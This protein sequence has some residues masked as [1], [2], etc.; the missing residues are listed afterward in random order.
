MKKY[1]IRI[2]NIFTGQRHS[3]VVTGEI[4]RIM[5]GLAVSGWIVQIHYSVDGENS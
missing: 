3:G 4:D 2:Q 5:K 1:F